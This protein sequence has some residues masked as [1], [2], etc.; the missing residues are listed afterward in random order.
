MREE[1]SAAELETAWTLTEQD[2]ERIGDRTGADR[3]MFAVLLKYSEIDG[4]FPEFREHVPAEAVTYVAEQ[5]DVDED[6][7]YLFPWR[8]RKIVE[9]AARIRP[10]TVVPRS[11]QRN[12]VT[13]LGLVLGG[14]LVAFAAV[15][16]VIG[17]GTD[18]TTHYKVV[19]AEPGGGCDDEALYLDTATGEQLSCVAGPT[20]PLSDIPPPEVPETWSA[21]SAAA[22]ESLAKRLSDGGIDAAEQERITDEADRLADEDGHNGHTAYVTALTTGVAGAALLLLA[23]IGILAIRRHRELETH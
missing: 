19:F 11:H 3:L 23:G 9:Y 21:G 5:V 12:K 6:E 10:G 13:S 1:W 17:I 18:A 22:V 15:S 16:L 8:R 7:F 4:G 14:V 20:T 2:R